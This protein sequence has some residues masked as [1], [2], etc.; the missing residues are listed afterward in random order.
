MISLRVV[1]NVA[2]YWFRSCSGDYDCRQEDSARRDPLGGW[3]SIG[4]LC[5][6]IIP[7]TVMTKDTLD[8]FIETPRLYISAFDAGND[9]HCD[10]L[11]DLYT[12][13]ESIK[14]FGKTGLDNRERA[15]KFI[16][17][18]MRQCSKRN[19]YGHWLVSLKP[20]G[21]TSST[22]PAA[23]KDATPIGTVSFMR[24]T[25]PDA[26]AVPDLGFI[27]HPKYMRKGYTIEACAAAMEYASTTYNLPGF[28]GLTDTKNTASQGIFRKLGFTDRGVL[29]VRVFGGKESSVW[30]KGVELDEVGFYA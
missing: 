5:C 13:D 21:T 22:E 17:G 26:Y 20:E 1:W 6:L 28:L 27:M 10:L 19:G 7:T 3:Q 25:P 18:F 2:W 9:A 15:G 14:A 23:L 16:N 29:P 8:A 24:G 11:V 12:S 4:H 30:T